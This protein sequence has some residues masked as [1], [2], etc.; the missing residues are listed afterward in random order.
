MSFPDPNDSQSHTIGNKVWNWDGAKWI[1]QTVTVGAPAFAA[2]DPVQVDT[3][4]TTTTYSLDATTL[5]PVDSVAGGASST[6]SSGGA[7]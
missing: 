7:Y 4:A 3:Q 2:I 6:A 1:L 5:D